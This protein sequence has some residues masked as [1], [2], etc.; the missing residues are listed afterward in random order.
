[1]KNK[2][3]KKLKTCTCRETY[4]QSDSQSHTRYT[5]KSAAVLTYLYVHVGESDIVCL[6]NDLIN[7]YY[8]TYDDII[9]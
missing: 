5:S 4:K 3:H 7:G 8:E 6:I 2:T 9:L 1:M